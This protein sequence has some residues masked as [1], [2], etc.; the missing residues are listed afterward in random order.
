MQIE[1]V[2]ETFQTTNLPP[3]PAD[4]EAIKRRNLGDA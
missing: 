4:F 1:Q 3:L 2:G